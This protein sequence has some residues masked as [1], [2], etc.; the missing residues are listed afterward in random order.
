VTLVIDGVGFSADLTGQAL[1][2]PSAIGVIVSPYLPDASTAA[3]EARAHGHAVLLSLPMEPSQGA[4]DDEGPQQL[5]G[6][7]TPQEDQDALTWALSRLPHPDGVTDLASGM[8]GG[9]FVSSPDFDPIARRLEEAHLAFIEAEPGR[10]RTAPGATADVS[11]DGDSDAAGI[12]RQ[13]AAL[14]TVAAR[15]GHALGVAGPLTP[16]LLARITEWSK[17]LQAVRLVPVSRLTEHE[18]PSPLE[19]AAV[20]A[21]PLPASASPVAGGADVSKPGVQAAAP[22]N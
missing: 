15:N 12:D 8:T 19:T 5:G 20:S 11:I 10:A 3:D 6:A 9:A 13:L 4:R 16:A 2:L 22:T 18:A 17:D 1:A 21:A 14:T 7:H